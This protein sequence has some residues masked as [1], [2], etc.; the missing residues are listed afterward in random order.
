MSREQRLHYMKTGVRPMSLTEA[1]YDA[2]SH[3]VLK[4]TQL[5]LAPLIQQEQNATMK[6]HTDGIKK[7]L[8]GMYKLEMTNIDRSFRNETEQID[9]EKAV[10]KDTEREEAK[11]LQETI[12]A[13]MAKDKKAAMKTITEFNDKAAAIQT[14]AKKEKRKVTKAEMAPLVAL[15]KAQQQHAKSIKKGMPCIRA[16]MAAVGNLDKIPESNKACEGFQTGLAA[17]MK[18]AH[19][20]YVGRQK[21]RSGNLRTFLQQHMKLRMACRYEGGTRQGHAFS[22]TE[23]CGVM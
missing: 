17:E 6:N 10:L 16:T 23:S 7:N 19:Q 11:N 22:K 9:N 13:E 12:R 20:R 8:G 14:K 18:R 15:A 5:R 3:H 2:M 21:K 1:E 4:R